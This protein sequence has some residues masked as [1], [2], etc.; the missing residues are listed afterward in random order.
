M[1]SGQFFELQSEARSIIK[2]SSL[3]GLP[4]FQ[5]TIMVYVNVPKEYSQWTHQ[6]CW[7]KSST[8][9]LLAFLK[10]HP[11]FSSCDEARSHW[12]I[13]SHWRSWSWGDCY[14]PHF[15]SRLDRCNMVQS[16]ICLE[17]NGR[18]ILNLISLVSF[19]DSLSWHHG[20]HRHKMKTHWQEDP[21]VL[22]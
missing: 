4:S 18:V 7:Q 21:E 2:T 11:S 9:F 16:Q 3:T 13:W 17:K 14:A 10:S 12:Q 15:T 20:S 19:S 5:A 22:L 8:R 1:K 6:Q